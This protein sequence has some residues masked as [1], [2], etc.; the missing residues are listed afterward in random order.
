MR[1]SRSI[2]TVVL[3]A[4]LLAVAGWAFARALE[5][6]PASP[7]RQGPRVTTVSAVQRRSL[8]GANEI[9]A[10]YVGAG[11]CA[12]AAC[13][14]D[15]SSAN[16]PSWKN[17][18]SRWI[19]Q[20]DPHS[21]A[22]SVLK[23]ETSKRIL[24]LLDGG[25]G[26]PQAEKNQPWSNA[27]PHRDN[28]CLTCHSI[29]PDAHTQLPESLLA[30]GVSCEGC[31]GPA[32]SWIASHTT[33][34]W[35]ADG[36]KRYQ[37][38]G[39][40]AGVGRDNRAATA[41][42]RM[43][44]TKDPVSRANLCVRCHVGGPDRDVNHDLIAAGHPRLNFEYHAFM[45]NL[46][47]HWN[48]ELDRERLQIEPQSTAAK[49]A[50]YE[51]RLW[52]IGQAASAQAALQL[53][54]QRVN[55]T[56]QTQPAQL[57]EEIASERGWRHGA[58]APAW[59]ELAEY[60]CYACHHD[61]KGPRITSSDPQTRRRPLGSLP[62]GT[63]YF[64]EVQSKLFSAEG[65]GL[66]ALGA[67]VEPVRKAMEK[68]VAQPKE[69]AAQLLGDGDSTATQRSRPYQ[70]RVALAD[71]ERWLAALSELPPPESWDEATQRYLALNALTKSHRKLAGQYAKL[72][73]G[74]IE[75]DLEEI[76]KRLQFE[77]GYQ[78]PGHLNFDGLKQLH[79]RLFKVRELL[80][81]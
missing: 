69:V 22:Y 74:A 35:L 11:G 53:L 56:V 48:D 34:G 66:P 63:W 54:E 44:N 7:D 64:S 47:R 6:P 25:Q 45:A 28:R 50:D 24:W 4:P 71:V 77:P 51:A 5:A 13:H 62:W 55:R 30:D 27:A 20:R 15:A 3:G 60:S 10:R 23:S 78:S 33:V 38:V 43:R 65:A 9:A 16:S 12:A 46:P 32:D 70:K 8:A 17:S 21:I 68:P 31:H 41:D 39:Q 14:G 73:Y 61:I 29:T 75:R 80:Q 52:A 40:G 49:P 19:G 59:P 72:D 57:P 26:D 18:Y 42:A 76:R 1:L 37:F 36:A 79:E 2:L 58:I 81:P 67:M